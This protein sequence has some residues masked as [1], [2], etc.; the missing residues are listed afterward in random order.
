[1]KKI[2]KK[3]LIIKDEDG[4]LS[5][6]SYVLGDDFSIPEN[7][8]GMGVILE[9][10]CSN[11]DHLYYDANLKAI[12]II[13]SNPEL[14]KEVE[15]KLAIIYNNGNDIADLIHKARRLVVETDE[16]IGEIYEKYE[17][18]IETND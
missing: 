10:I 3:E 4:A 2:N 7:K 17:D 13:T 1:M 12:K 15:N 6:H 16:S 18:N 9:I 8:N 14:K 11:L 5:A